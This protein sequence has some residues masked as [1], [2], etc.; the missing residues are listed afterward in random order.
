MEAVYDQR[1]AIE[2]LAVTLAGDYYKHA[3]NAERES[4]VGTLC[5]NI[6]P[7]CL[8]RF[9]TAILF[10]DPDESV[11]AIDTLR[12]LVNLQVNEESMPAM[13]AEARDRLAERVG[14]AWVDQGLPA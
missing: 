13:R 2:S 7:D 14:D 5:G 9:I 4:A 11:T 3:S 12:S 8:A 10:G 6:D 1:D